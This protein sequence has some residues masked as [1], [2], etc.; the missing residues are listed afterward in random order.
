[1][2]DTYENTYKD[3]QHT[4]KQMIFYASVQQFLTKRVR[5]KNSKTSLWFWHLEDFIP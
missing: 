5:A 3:M 4:I 1:M 2:I